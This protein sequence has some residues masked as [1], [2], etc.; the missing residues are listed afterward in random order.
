MVRRSARARRGPCDHRNADR[1]S[2]IEAP[3]Q[4]PPPRSE[5][6]QTRRSRRAAHRARHA[7]MRRRLASSRAAKTIDPE[8]C[9]TPP[10]CRAAVA[11]GHPA[12][13]AAE[14]R[15][16]S[17]GERRRR[18]GDPGGRHD[19][20]RLRQDESRRR[21]GAPHH[22]RSDPCRRRS[23]RRRVQIRTR[24]ACGP[25]QDQGPDECRAGT[26]SNR[27]GRSASARRRPARAAPA[28]MD[29]RTSRAG[30][31]DR[32]RS[33]VRHA[34]PPRSSDAPGG[35]CVKSLRAAGRAALDADPTPSPA[36][37]RWPVRASA[38]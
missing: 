20:P 19:E 36:I 17:H 26:P 23:M 38:W 28:A 9:T 32:S 7:A 30:L 8:R 37:A 15:G 13:P 35:P 6:A 11:R 10:A 33:N 31:E 4:A 27:L 18:R 3:A 34:S 22:Q 14:T 16:P 24:A 12:K 2:R 1:T 29:R 5:H 25:L 21:H